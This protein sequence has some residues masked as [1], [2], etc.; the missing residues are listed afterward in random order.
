MINPG[1]IV[2]ARFPERQE[3]SLLEHE[4]FDRWRRAL[5]VVAR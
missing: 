2:D 5:G 3:A 1:N 4:P